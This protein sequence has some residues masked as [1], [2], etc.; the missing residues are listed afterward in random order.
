MGKAIKKPIEIE[1]ITFEDFVEYGKQNSSNIAENGMP[2]SFDYKGHPISHE[3]DEAY[4]IPTLEGTLLFTPNEV[5]I[6]GVKG[7]IYPCRKDIF[8]ATYDIVNTAEEKDTFLSRLEKEKNQLEERL[9]KLDYFL[10]S[11]KVKSIDDVQHALLCVQATAMNT[12]L[13]CLKERLERL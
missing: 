9:N 13:R 8:E 5:L 1:F 3:N 12:Y 2:W 6:T 11:E 10:E 7:E 4:V